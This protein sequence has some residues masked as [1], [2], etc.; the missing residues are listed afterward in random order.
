MSTKLCKM[1]TYGEAKLI[2]SSHNSDHEIKRGH[3]S[4]ENLISVLLHG[5]YRQTIAMFRARKPPMES[6]DS[7]TMQSREVT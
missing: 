7:L 1:L 2:M 6:H 4:S 3:V 5:L